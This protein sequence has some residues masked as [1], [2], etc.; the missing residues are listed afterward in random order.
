MNLLKYYIMDRINSTVDTFLESLRERDI[1]IKLNDKDN[2]EIE[3]PKGALQEDLVNSVRLYRETIIDYL[4]AARAQAEAGQGIPVAPAGDSYPL[5]SAQTRVWVSS[6]IHGADLYNIVS[7]YEINEVIDPGVFREAIDM[8][9]ERHE[10]LRTAFRKDDSG[11]A[12]QW[13]MPSGKME[14]DLTCLDWSEGLQGRQ[15]ADEY[16]RRQISSQPFDL[17]RAPLFRVVVIK[18]SGGRSIICYTM[19]HIITDAWSTKILVHDVFVVYRSIQQGERAALP[20]LRIQY[21]DFAVW[22]QAQLETPAFQA[23][24]EYWLNKFQGELPALDLVPNV[25]RPPIKN[26]NGQ[27]LGTYL[28]REL[29]SPLKEICI[30]AGGSLF[31]GLVA[32]VLAILYKYTGQRDIIIGTPVAGREHPDLQSQ[33]GFYINTIPLRNRLEGKGSFTDLFHT[34]SATAMEAHAH[35]AYPFDRLIEKLQL[36]RDA[37]RSLLFD[38]FL[39]FQH[40]LEDGASAGDPASVENGAS[41]GDDGPAGTAADEISD[42]GLSSS[43][44][45][46]IFNFSE[47]GEAIHL[48]VE[49]NRDVYTRS[50]IEKFI[51]HYKELLA[52]LIADP[53]APLDRLSYMP[54]EE[55]RQLSG[56]AEGA[57]LTYQPETIVDLFLSQVDRVPNH[58]ALWSGTDRMTYRELHERSNRVANYLRAKGVKEEDLVALFLDRSVRAVVCILGILK[59]GGA[60]MPVDRV[61]PAE[62]VAGILSGSRAGFMLTDK[63]GLELIAGLSRPELTVLDADDDEIAAASTETP[64]GRIASSQLAYVL[65]TSGSTGA[66]KGVQVEHGSLTNYLRWVLTAYIPGEQDG[67]FGL[68]TTLSFDL[69][70]TSLFGALVKGAML[71]VYPQDMPVEDILAHYLNNKE[72]DLIKLTPAHLQLIASLGIKSTHLKNFIVGG[73][74]LRR[75]HLDVIFRISPDAVVYNEYGP[76]EA[77]VGCT[78]ATIRR[79]DTGI[80]SIGRPIINNSIYILDEQLDVSPLGFTGEI[81]I[82]GLQLARGYLHMDELTRAKFIHHPFK[83]GELLYKTGDFGRWLPDGNIEY[84]GRQDGQVKIRGYRIETGE[85]ETALRQNKDIRDVVVMSRSVSWEDNDLV[86]YI[87][88]SV[89]IDKEALR[90]DLKSRLPEYMIPKSY[91]MVSKLPLTSNGKVDRKKL[92]QEAD[93]YANAAREEYVAPQNEVESRLAELWKT[94]LAAGREISTKESFFELGGHSIKAIKM[95]AQVSKEYKVVVSVGQLFEEP[96]IQKLAERIYSSGWSKVPAASTAAAAE[97]YDNVKI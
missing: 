68:F 89:R 56:F 3:A 43:K 8:V 26:T 50:T 22:Q 38:V 16:I 37:S 78:V 9:V 76:T 77:T 48:A 7:T 45:D 55:R 69:T 84:T 85:I 93:I 91:I 81:H 13:V 25:T 64:A 97:E 35:Q 46:L 6:Q 33:I 36:Q 71:Y 65:Y 87:V 66:P 63:K 90:A 67:N 20:P 4:K 1:F 34:V 27:V 62:K 44:F 49:F 19:H 47:A 58:V 95:L 82:G 88:S 40:N 2:L 70:F 74:Q 51:G 29:A 10:I 41:A 52:A 17:E 94:V 54:V 14:V 59:A 31:S 96:T 73:E 72:L 86:A 80:I 61:H 92:L 30:R 83:E 24:E 60:F 42:L 79:G 23:H 28:P 53:L 57:K 12:R 5:S 21:K 11:Q 39:N 75:Q 15:E 32:S 18:L